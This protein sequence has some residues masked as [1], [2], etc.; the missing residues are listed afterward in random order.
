MK[1]LMSIIL[2]VVLATG[3]LGFATAFAEEGERK[4]ILTVGI[5]AEYA[6]FEYI[7][8][9]DFKGI[10]I[11]IMKT[12]A[13]EAGY[14]EVVFVNMEFSALVSA[15]NEGVVDCAISTIT[16][17]EERDA[18]VD[19]TTPYA[20]AKVN[21]IEDGKVTEKIEKYCVIFK[22][23]AAENPRSKYADINEE[24]T[25]W[26]EMEGAKV[27]AKGEK[28]LTVAKEGTEYDFEF[29]VNVSGEILTGAEQLSAVDSIYSDW[30]EEYMVRATEIGWVPIKEN[31]SYNITRGEFCTLIGLNFLYSCGLDVNFWG[32]KSPFTDIDDSTVGDKT[33][34]DYLYGLDIVDGKSETLFCPDDYL[35]REEAAVI[36]VRIID[37]FRKWDVTDINTDVVNDWA[38]TD[39]KEISDWANNAVYTVSNLGIMQGTDKGF[40]PKN[41]LTYEQTIVMLLRLY[42]LRWGASPAGFSDKMNSV[43]PL[44][45]NYVFSPL[46]VKMA[47]MLTANGADD[48][49]Q[50]EI[51][52]LFDEDDV[53]WYNEKVKKMIEEYSESEFLYTNIANSVWVNKSKTDADFT[54]EF[55][56]NAEGYY[57]A[58]IGAVD[59]AN[60][61]E[62]VNNWISEKT[63][64]K[65]DSILPDDFND[66]YLA[67]VNAIYFNGKWENKFDQ[68]DTKPGIF[69]NADGSK[70][71]TMFM[72][73]TDYFNYYSD[74]VTQIVEMPYETYFECY[75]ED[76]DEISLDLDISMYLVMSNEDINVAEKIRH[77]SDGADMSSR[78]VRL[79]VPKFEVEYSDSFK[80][81]LISLGFEKTFSSEFNNILENEPMFVDDVLHKTYIKI[82][83]EGTEAAAITAVTLLGMGMPERPA[84]FIADKPFYFVIRDNKNGEILFMGR[85]AYVTE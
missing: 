6:P 61:V 80:D 60:A 55:K 8:N 32:T 77:A 66:F 5:N 21:Y 25:Y 72:N 14:D 20:V 43:M 57:Q 13:N 50:D 19:F 18:V 27:Y 36:F 1:R 75:E 45:K 70:T 68:D 54:D 53:A 64:E 29:T 49:T 83:E 4:N 9:G 47:L 48:E 28:G 3:V 51:C 10:D 34:I 84:E 23:G 56:K 78:R 26:N 42:D 74:G 35:T 15:V 46:S 82:D 22:E 2:L 69:T 62:A 73:Q 79:S 16:Y 59:E 37:A 81:E 31:Y 63:N 52:E 65:I 71:E 30:A 38:Y 11:D 58:N 12:I 44:D 67:V 76:S 85:Y 40:E 7:D 39:H 17:T 41:N 33:A 24:I